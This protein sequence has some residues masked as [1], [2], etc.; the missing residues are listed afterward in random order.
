MKVR[1]SEHEVTFVKQAEKSV[2]LGLAD[3]Y[4]NAAKKKVRFCWKG[5]FVGDAA[6]NLR[7]V[8]RGD[9]IRIVAGTAHVEVHGVKTENKV[10]VHEAAIVKKK[11]RVE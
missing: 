10:I 1:D 6:I 2:I 11:E 3:Y 7:D 9:I 4:I 5:I 8:Q